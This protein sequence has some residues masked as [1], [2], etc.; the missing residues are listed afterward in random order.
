MADRFKETRDI[1][2]ERIRKQRLEE[3]RKESDMDDKLADGFDLM[4]AD[5]GDTDDDVLSK[6]TNQ[7]IDDNTQ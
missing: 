4:D 5:E 6:F 1:H 3:K 2:Q 7:K